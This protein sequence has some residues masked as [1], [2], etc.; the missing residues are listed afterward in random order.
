M[1]GINLCWTQI[2]TPYGFLVSFLWNSTKRQSQEFKRYEHTRT[3]NKE[4]RHWQ[5]SDFSKCFRTGRQTGESG[6]GSVMEVSNWL[7][8]PKRIKVQRQGVAEDGCHSELQNWPWGHWVKVY[9]QKSWALLS[10]LPACEVLCGRL[11]MATNYLTLL[12][13]RGGDIS[14]LNLGR[15]RLLWPTEYGRTG[16]V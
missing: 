8:N 6:I 4:K 13:S 16:T 3:K 1:M 9:L 11:K 7:K 12:S 2:N 10:L 14:F 15:S 5:L